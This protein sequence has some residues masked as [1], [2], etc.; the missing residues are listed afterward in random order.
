MELSLQV[1]EEVQMFFTL[2]RDPG[3]EGCSPDYIESQIGGHL[4][5]IIDDS[6]WRLV[7]IS[8]HAKLAEIRPDRY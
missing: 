2:R 7:N 4:R 6:A 5:A 8:F 1:K 3:S